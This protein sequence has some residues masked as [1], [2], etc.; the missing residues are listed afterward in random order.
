MSEDRSKAPPARF[1]LGRTQIAALEVY[2]LDPAV[3]EYDG[4]FPGRLFLGGLEVAAGA[5]AAA[6]ERINEGSN[7]ADADGDRVYARALA[8][9]AGR[10]LR[11][12]Y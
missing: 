5:L 11:E 3:V 1:R 7:S 6:Y 10:V 12:G 4:P 8:D 9:L 2:V